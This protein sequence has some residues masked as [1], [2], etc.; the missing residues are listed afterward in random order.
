MKNF[1]LKFGLSSAALTAL[2]IAA[3]VLVNVL[4]SAI[5]DRTPLKIDLTKEKVYEFSSQ[6]ESIVKNIDEEIN[7]YALY[8]ENVDS[9]VINYAK[10]YLSKYSRMNKNIKVSYV[11]PY[12]NPNF[13]KKYEKTGESIEAGSLIVEN[14]DKVKVITIDSLY[15]QNNY[16][17]STSIDMEKKM[18]MALASVTGQSGNSKIYFTSGHGEMSSESI[19]SALEDEGYACEDLNLTFGGISEDAS[20]LFVVVPQKDF[21]GDEINIID[22]YMDGGGKI[23]YISSPGASRLEKLESY[24]GEW[25]IGLNRD[26]I[27][28]EDS[29]RAY[30]TRLGLPI[31]APKLLEH[32]ITSNI[33]KGDLI[34][35]AP[36]S[37]SISLSESN[38]RH[39]KLTPLLETSEKSYGKTNLS[40]EIIAKEEGDINGPL[41]VAALAEAQDQTGAKIAVLSSY[42]SMEQS[43]LDEATFANSDFL[44]NLAAYLTE[45][46]NPLDIRAK[47]ISASSI[48]MNQTQVIVTYIIVQYFIPIIIIAA[49]IIVWLKRRYL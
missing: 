2:V 19:T 30:Q 29:N 14:G 27:I 1:K 10:E 6:T 36:N 48:T 13:A 34:F 4:I 3:V 42:Y 26:Y 5:T 35:M 32:S 45:N 44:L 11:D 18:T 46:K 37:E 17:G 28:E 9:T 8:P 12:T 39:A 41:T 25:G 43:Y 40:S 49:G 21:T 38:I 22:E 20:V 31:P 47:V 23:F 7:I 16:T 15:S 24:L 33:I